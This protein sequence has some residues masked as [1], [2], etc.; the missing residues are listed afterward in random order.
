MTFRDTLDR[1]LRAIRTRDL[2]GLIDTLPADGLTLVMS[3]GKVV[4][5][6]DEF[7]ALHRGWFASASW[8]LNA[9]LIR[10]VEGRDLGLAVLRLDYRDHAPERAPIHE[11]SIL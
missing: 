10:A 7:V 4:W 5:S 9:E 3:D 11:T 2:T 6:V 8:S 1:H